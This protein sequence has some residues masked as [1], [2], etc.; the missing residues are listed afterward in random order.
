MSIERRMQTLSLSTGLGGSVW[1]F[2]NAAVHHQ[3]A[4]SLHSAAASQVTDSALT[5]PWMEISQ[6]RLLLCVVVVLAISLS[7]LSLFFG[8]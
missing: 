1:V 8:M 3:T 2:S 7:I 6:W 4:T 5:S